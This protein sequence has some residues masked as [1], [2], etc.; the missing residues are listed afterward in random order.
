MSLERKNAAR[1]GASTLSEIFKRGKDF[2]PGL[3]EARRVGGKEAGEEY[4]TLWQVKQATKGPKTPR[5][6]GE[7]PPLDRRDFTLSRK[8]MSQLREFFKTVQ[9]WPKEEKK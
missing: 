7:R 3:L 2:Y 4:R 5:E 9:G 8:E 6:L 1:T